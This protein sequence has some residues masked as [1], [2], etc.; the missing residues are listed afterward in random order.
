MLLPVAHGPCLL[1][2]FVP[3]TN[4]VPLARIKHVC[5]MWQRHANGRTRGGSVPVSVPF[6]RALPWRKNLK[7][8]ERTVTSE[9][10]K[11]SKKK[12]RTGGSTFEIGIV[13]WNLFGRTTHCENEM[14]KVIIYK[15][16]ARLL[17]DSSVN[18]YGCWEKLDTNWLIPHNFDPRYYST[19]N[20]THIK[21]HVDI[22]PHYVEHIFLKVQYRV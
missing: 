21:F 6:C 4:T 2:E 16:I 15:I 3:L 17:F 11:K 18:C 12:F 5:R 22:L 19:G 14:I 9:Y 7:S 20:S 10:K 8:E 1:H 13:I